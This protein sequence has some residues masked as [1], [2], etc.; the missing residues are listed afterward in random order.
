MRDFLRKSSAP[1]QYRGRDLN[2]HSH[3]W[4]KDFKSFV[5]T[6][7]TTAASGLNLYSKIRGKGT[8]FFSIDKKNQPFFSKMCIF[9]KKCRKMYIKFVYVKNM[10]YLCK[11]K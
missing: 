7:S 6:D 5:S 10:L 8:A 11:P 3:L 4:P 9:C 1:C 2:P